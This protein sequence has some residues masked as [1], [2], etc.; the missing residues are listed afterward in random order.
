MRQHAGAAVD[1]QLHIGNRNT[2]GRGDVG[3]IG[4]AGLPDTLDLASAGIEPEGIGGR[5]QPGA[6]EHLLIERVRQRPPGLTEVKVARGVKPTGVLET[7]RDVQAVPEVGVGPVDRRQQVLA[8][9]WRLVAHCA[10]FGHRWRTQVHSKVD[11]QVG[12]CVPVAYRLAQHAALSVLQAHD[13]IRA[14]DLAHAAPELA[15]LELDAEPAIGT[16]GFRSQNV[17]PCDILINDDNVDAAQR[18]ALRIHDQSEDRMHSF[19]A[20]SGHGQCQR[21][22]DICHWPTKLAPQ[23]QEPMHAGQH[24]SQI[25]GH[26]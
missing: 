23:A 21:S 20:R 12:N 13:H 6:Q 10:R 5:G 7:A 26:R 15:F 1:Q 14:T 16:G 17:F 8:D 9:A 2:T 3:G 4:A 18:L 24:A 11:V 25:P 19:W 22:I